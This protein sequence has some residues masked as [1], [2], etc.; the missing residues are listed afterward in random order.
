MVKSEEKYIAA[1]NPFSEVGKE[2]VRNAPPFDSLSQEIKD[3]AVDR[4]NESSGPEVK[5]QFEED[6]VRKDVLSFYLMCQ[7]VAAVSYPYSNEATRITEATRKTIRYR[8]YDLF[9]RGY[10]KICFEAIN[11]SFRLR[12]LDEEDGRLGSKKIPEEDISDLRDLEL[13]R[14]GID[15]VDENI[16]SQFTPKYAIRWPDLIPL[17]DNKRL[18]LTDQ[19]LVD[20]WVLIPPKTLWDFFGT[21]VESKMMEYVSELYDRFSRS[22]PPSE[23]LEEVGE[24]ISEA[25]PENK[26]SREFSGYSGGKLKPEAF[27]PCVKKALNGVPSGNRNYAVI[28]LLTP[29]LSYA[30]ISPS[31]KSVN[32][33]ADFVDDISV[34]EED[35]VPLIFEAAQ[36][37]NPPLFEDQPQDKSNVYYHMGFAMTTQPRLGDSGKSKW[38]RPP[39]CR[40]IKSESPALCN[41]DDLCSEVKNPLTYYYKSLSKSSEKEEG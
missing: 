19:Y 13:E 16:V 17:M 30:R 27:P 5:V 32:R 28:M 39:N 29:F 22:R 41:P 4:V 31:G 40:K 3:L 37:C 18:D 14:E 2:I 12:K 33:I 25:V 35:I 7:S 34:I 15:Q 1:L 26:S 8:M 24:R 23:V 9:R 36:N 20:G 38:Y 21:F 11:R 6:E 10:E